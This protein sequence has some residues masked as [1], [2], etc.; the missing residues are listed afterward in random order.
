MD[1]PNQ[2]N[3]YGRARKRTALILFTTGKTDALSRF[4]D[5][6]L[7]ILISLNI[8]A[9]ILESVRGIHAVAEDF[10]YVFEVFSVTVFSLEY[11]ARV[12]SVV[13]NPWNPAHAHP[14]KGRIKYMLTWMAV[15]DLVAIAP[16]YLSFFA[17]DD[18]RV[19]RALRLLR[20]FK[21]TRYSSAMTLLF[22]VFREE[23]RTI[24]AAMFVS[25]LLMFVASTLAFV[26]EHP[27][28]PDKFSSIPAAMYWA[29]IT[30]TTVGYGDIV[31]LTPWGKMLGAFIGIIGLGM[32][33]LPAGI[34]ASGFGNAL[35]RRRAILEEHVQEIMEDGIITVAEQ[36]AL[37]Q[38]VEQ[39]NLSDLDTRAIMHA[40]R[41]K[42]AQ[43][44][45][46]TCP[47]CGKQIHDSDGSDTDNPDTGA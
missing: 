26:V 30:M 42:Q 40:V 21:L 20:I 4:V 31:P 24:G 22:Q 39:L 28:Q 34:L 17:A 2:L 16:F 14:L 9:V 46:E 35:H 3:L 37:E 27:V 33:A 15:I 36:N 8:L 6:G 10:F 41:V 5:I 29:T 43:E 12:W 47:H 13:D 25:T 11:I 32:V 44:A 45:M 38:L 19:L 1:G 18:L 7:I 23:A